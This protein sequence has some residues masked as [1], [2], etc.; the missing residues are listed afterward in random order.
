MKVVVSN[1]IKIGVIYVRISCFK[2]L[3]STVRPREDIILFDKN[4]LAHPKMLFI[5]QGAAN[6]I[7]NT[8]VL[9]RLSSRLDS[10]TTNRICLTI[11]ELVN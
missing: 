8:S 6:V 1:V 5:S 3:N 9:H 11:E 2:L 4:C 7:Y 10:E